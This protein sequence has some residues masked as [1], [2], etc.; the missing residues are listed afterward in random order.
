MRLG[1]VHR[2]ALSR[3]MKKQLAEIAQSLDALI[4]SAASSTS[5]WHEVR[6]LAYAAAEAMGAENSS[7]HRL[8]R[9]YRDEL[10]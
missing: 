10:P 4:K 7:W 6:A 5:A 8:V 9:R 1:F 3:D 2:A